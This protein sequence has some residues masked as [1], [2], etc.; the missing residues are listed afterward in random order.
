MRNNA[1][2][3]QF[4][5]SEEG[6]EAAKSAVANLLEGLTQHAEELKETGLNFIIQQ[7][8]TRHIVVR[9]P[10]AILVFDWQHRYT[11]SLDHAWLQVGF[12]DTMPKLPGL[13]VFD[14]PQELEIAR[15]EFKLI[16]PQRPAWVCGE[17]EVTPNNMAEYLMKRLMHHNETELQRGR[18]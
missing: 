14:D 18:R 5:T 1:E 13:V 11:N 16:G 12:Y 2:A 10:N 15:F 4:R 6:V 8:R 9:S 17:T 7:L 3:E